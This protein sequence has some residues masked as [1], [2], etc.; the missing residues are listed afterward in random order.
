MILP[1]AAQRKASLTPVND[2]TNADA[3]ADNEDVAN[4]TVNSGNTSDNE[5]AALLDES[6]LA[7]L[8]TDLTTLT[9]DAEDDEYELDRDRE[10][11]DEKT[12]EEIIKEVEDENTLTETEKRTARYAVT[13]VHLILIRSESYL[14]C[15]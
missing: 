13:K 5:L 4:A 11:L 8:D 3:T 2:K 14:C 9:D 12:I 10:A 1:L 15:L 6:D 7:E